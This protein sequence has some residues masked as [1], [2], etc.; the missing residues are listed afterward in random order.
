MASVQSMRRELWQAGKASILMKRQLDK[1]D[2]QLKDM[3]KRLAAMTDERNS[4]KA[5]LRD[6]SASL[7][8]SSKVCTVKST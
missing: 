3:E 1:K 5:R 7:P 4:L 8:A 2:W 6:Q